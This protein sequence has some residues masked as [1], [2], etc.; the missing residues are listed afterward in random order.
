MDIIIRFFSEKD[1]RVETRYF[2]SVFLHTASATDLLDKFK[3]G[4]EQLNFGKILQVGI[5]FIFSN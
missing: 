5:I 2:N 4:L 1:N 3:E